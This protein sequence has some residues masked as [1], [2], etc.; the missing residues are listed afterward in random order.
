[1]RFSIP[2]GSC[3]RFM[4]IDLDATGLTASSPSR[5]DAHS[6]TFG[7]GCTNCSYSKRSPRPQHLPHRVPRH[8]QVTCDLLDLA[9]DEL[10]A[11]YPRN[12]LHDQHPQ[13]PASFQSKQRNRSNWREQNAICGTIRLQLLKIGALVTVSVCRVKVAFASWCPTADA[14][15]RAQ[16]LS[17]TAV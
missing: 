4:V 16:G 17:S 15:V 10:L 5:F 2:T 7:R 13:P 1:M 3:A 14:C 6:P 9:L 12:R 8:L 11:P